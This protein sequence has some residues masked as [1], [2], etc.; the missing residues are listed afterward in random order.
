MVKARRKKATIKLTPGEHTIETRAKRR[1]KWVKQTVEIPAGQL[2]PG[3]AK[4]G[5]YDW[6]AVLTYLNPCG[7]P[8]V[9]SG[10]DRGHVQIWRH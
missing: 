3:D 1:G 7:E 9:L 6:R 8:G 4:P 2:P 5:F 10:Y